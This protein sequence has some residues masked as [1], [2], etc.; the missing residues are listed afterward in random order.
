MMAGSPE[1]AATGLVRAMRGLSPTMVERMKAG[2][3]YSN[4]WRETPQLLKNFAAS[5][6]LGAVAGGVGGNNLTS[7][8]ASPLQ[9]GGD[10]AAGALAGGGLGANLGK[11]AELMDV[12]ENGMRSAYLDHLDRVLGPTGN[13][14]EE[15]ARHAKVVQDLGGY[16]HTSQLI[17]FMQG[18][19]G[20]FIGYRGGAAPR[21]FLSAMA[22]HPGVVTNT[23]RMIGQTGH[24]ALPANQGSSDPSQDPVE[25]HAGGPMDEPI[26]LGADIASL[27]R[28]GFISSPATIGAIPGGIIRGAKE[29]YYNQTH[30]QSLEEMALGVGQ[31]GL[32]FVPGG[33]AVSSLVPGASPYKDNTGLPFWAQECF[34]LFNIYSKKQNARTAKMETKGYN[35]A[36]DR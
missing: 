28:E 11:M 9:R 4:F 17:Q 22:H 27:G 8:N 13:Q 20:T 33:S 5:S 34:N 10:I 29:A 21:A 6:G 35:R 25:L 30:P 32:G 14:A 31:Y 1:V 36:E 19:G 23:E 3:S 2:G 24:V 16:E 18:L 26:E 15:F 12:V 7:A